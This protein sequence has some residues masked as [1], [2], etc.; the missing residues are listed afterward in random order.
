MASIDDLEH[1]EIRSRAQWRAWPAKN[2][3]GPR[4]IWLVYFKKTARPDLHAH[5]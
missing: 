5:E 3:R 2:H 4:S 1:V